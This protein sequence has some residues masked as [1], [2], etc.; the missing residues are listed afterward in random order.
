MIPNPQ[1]MSKI[2]ETLLGKKSLIVSYSFSN[3]FLFYLF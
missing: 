2:F 3:K 1:P